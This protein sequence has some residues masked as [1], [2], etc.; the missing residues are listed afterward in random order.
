MLLAHP[1]TPSAMHMCE[2]IFVLPLVLSE[3]RKLT[4]FF[5]KNTI[6]ERFSSP[7][8]LGAYH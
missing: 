2:S 6:N 7:E 4:F 3:R 5:Q 8:T 1:I